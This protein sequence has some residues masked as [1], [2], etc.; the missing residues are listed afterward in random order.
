MQTSLVAIGGGGGGGGHVC[1]LTQ[2]ATVPGDCSRRHVAP[3]L[4]GGM[5]QHLLRS[6]DR[7]TLFHPRNPQKRDLAVAI[8]ILNL[9][10]CTGVLWLFGG[11]NRHA[12]PCRE[13]EVEVQCIYMGTY[14]LFPAFV[15]TSLL[16]LVL[17]LVGHTVRRSLLSLFSRTRTTCLPAYLSRESYH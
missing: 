2:S 17:I 6:P 12:V 7:P 4:C 5:A 16:R 3:L 8:T 14:Q 15:L 9:G 1:G 11:P 13:V 10:V